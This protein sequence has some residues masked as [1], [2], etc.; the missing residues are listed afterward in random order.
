M[1]AQVVQTMI[2]YDDRFVKYSSDFYEKRVV[3]KPFLP[4]Y[5]EAVISQYDADTVIHVILYDTKDENNETYLSEAKDILNRENVVVHVIS[6]RSYYILPECPK[7]YY[8]VE[9]NKQTDKKIQKLKQLIHDDPNKD[10]VMLVVCE[11]FRAITL[12]YSRP[13]QDNP[14]T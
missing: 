14:A 7:I 13:A 6:P 3:H 9:I 10:N 2:I 8:Y 11:D 4:Q 12:N 5:L 1:S